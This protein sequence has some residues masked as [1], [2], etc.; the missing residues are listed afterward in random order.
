MEALWWKF[1]LPGLGTHQVRA[2]NL[3]LQ[4][5]EVCIDGTHVPAP[6][7]QL[8]FTGP[9]ACLLEFQPRCDGWILFVDGVPTQSYNPHE[10]QATLWKFSLPGIGTHQL[11]IK[12]IGEMSQEVFIDGSPVEAPAGTTTFTGPGA[13]LLE[14]SRGGAEGWTLHVDGQY[15]PQ[16]L[17]AGNGTKPSK[18][19][20]FVLPAT[21]AH[22]VHLDGT[23]VYIDGVPAAAPPG[24]TT[25][26]GPEGCLL[27][28]QGG[29]DSWSLHVD[30]V[31]VPETQ[32]EAAAGPS[33][34]LWNFSVLDPTRTFSTMHQMRAFNIGQH[35]QQVYLD[36]VLV[37]APDGSMAFTGPGGCLLEVKSGPGCW[38]LDIDGQDMESH[39]AAVLSA[40]SANA[41]A[42]AREPVVPAA[43]TSL[44]QGVSLD[45]VSGRYTANIRV[46]GRFMNLGEFATPEEASARYQQER[47]KQS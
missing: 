11:R 21:G 41:P 16:S 9:G 36:G 38:K 1:D 46:H 6:D 30:G 39:N 4:G 18:V 23:Q 10:G 22:S 31:Q 12:H 17:S 14:I 5:Q 47:S 37:P 25:F 28:L 29:G 3:G 8:I 40:A 44:P 7:S 33:E 34:G 42:G 13:C 15:C 43:M 45:P 2:R 32:S 20:E 24:T 26:T 19:W 27:Q 35:G